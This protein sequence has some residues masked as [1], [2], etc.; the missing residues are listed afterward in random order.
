VAERLDEVVLVGSTVEDGLPD[1]RAVP[2]LREPP[3]LRWVAREQVR[4]FRLD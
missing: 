3:E 4:V 1:V 2:V